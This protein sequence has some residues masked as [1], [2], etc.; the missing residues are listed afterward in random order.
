[1]CLH[2][3]CKDMNDINVYHFTSVEEYH[4][5]RGLV[6]YWAARLP[7]SEQIG[8]RRD[9][10]LSYVREQLIFDVREQGLVRPRLATNSC[11]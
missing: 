11:Q 10:E 3:Y 8:R 9:R 7:G 2:N 4:E 6:R 5:I 1:M